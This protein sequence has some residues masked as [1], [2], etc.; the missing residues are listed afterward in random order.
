MCM[1][2]RVRPA[3]WANQETR[4]MKISSLTVCFCVCFSIALLF[5]SISLFTHRMANHMQ[6]YVNDVQIYQ[7]NIKVESGV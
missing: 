7:Q 4:Y 2:D 1:F 5:I 6:I 3:I